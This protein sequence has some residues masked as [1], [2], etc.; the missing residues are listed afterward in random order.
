VAAEAVKVFYSYSRKDQALREKLDQHLAPLKFGGQI[1][2]WHDLRLEPGSDWKKDIDNQLDTAHIILLLVS[3]NFLSSE[4]CYSIELKRALERDA[5]QEACVIPVILEPCDWKHDWIPF[6]K[7]TALPNHEKAITEWEHREAAFANVAQ[8]IRVKVQSLIQQRQAEVEQP[9]Q[10]ESERQQQAQLKQEAEKKRQQELANPQKQS[11]ATDE[12]SS[13]RGINYTRL[14]N[15]LKAGKWQEAD[16]ETAKQMCEVMRRRKEGWLSKKD[17]QQFP[18]TDL[19]TIDRL[20]V[21]YSNDKFGFSIQ[22]S[23]WQDCGSPE[24][25]NTSFIE[26][27]SR[28]GWMRS[29]DFLGLTYEW[30]W[31]SYKEITFN[32]SAPKGHLPVLGHLPIYLYPNGNFDI[33]IV[34][35]SEQVEAGWGSDDRKG[36][37]WGLHLISS[38]AHRLVECSKSQ[39]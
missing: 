21:K 4:Y 1:S 35:H 8:S 22:K 12:L 5:R 17:I 29:K 37:S 34:S 14:R 9:R 25:H 38:L 19:C 16:Q 23:I 36:F 33:Q 10:L 11:I 39:P 28:A 24:E 32:T 13:D 20:W 18:C 31:L 3:A 7:L 26:L 30:N 2:T 15:L 27:G 6:S